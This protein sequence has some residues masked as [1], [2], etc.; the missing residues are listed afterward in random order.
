MKKA[1]LGLILALAAASATAWEVHYFDQEV[2]LSGTLKTMPQGWPSLT[3]NQPIDVLPDP[4]DPDEFSETQTGV[5]LL[6][7]ALLPEHQPAYRRFKGHTAR[8]RCQLY[9]YHTAHHRTPVMCDVKA[10][11]PANRP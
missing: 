10:I 2:W 6:H 11:A 7:L 9:Y 5:R 1:M 8:V 4:Q 3:L